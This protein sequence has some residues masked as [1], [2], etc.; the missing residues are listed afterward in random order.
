MLTTNT[1]D[2]EEPPF[3][4][5]YSAVE[6]PPSKRKILQAALHLFVQRSV[7]GVTVREIAAEAGYTNPAL[8][9]YFPTKEAAASLVAG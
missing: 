4:A 8:F 2:H 6:D 9:K 7:D 3:R 1:K 5:A